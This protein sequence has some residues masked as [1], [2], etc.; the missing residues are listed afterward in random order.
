M[1][2]INLFFSSLPIIV[3]VL[4]VPIW[5]S[6]P[7]RPCCLTVRNAVSLQ[8]IAVSALESASAF[9]GQSPANG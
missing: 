5:I 8:P 4:E 1:S 2:P 6:L 9:L 3:A 7:E